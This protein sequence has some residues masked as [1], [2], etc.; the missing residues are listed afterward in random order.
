M[1]KFRL[2][3]EQAFSTFLE[4]LYWEMDGNKSMCVDSYILEHYERKTSSVLAAWLELRSINAKIPIENKTN[5][6]RMWSRLFFDFQIFDDLKDIKQD[7]NKQP[8]LL[9]LTANSYPTEAEWLKN[10]IGDLSID[11]DLHGTLKINLNMPLSVT[12]LKLVSSVNANYYLSPFLKAV[13]N[14][15]WKKSW[16]SPFLSFQSKKKPIYVDEICNLNLKFNNA[17]KPLTKVTLSAIMSTI[18][19]Y[20]ETSSIE[21]MFAHCLDI[22]ALDKRGFIYRYGSLRGVWNYTLYAPTMSLRNKQSLFIEVLNNG[23]VI[24]DI[25]YWLNYLS[26]HNNS[27][28]EIIKYLK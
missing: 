14:Y 10:N 7:F 1:E 5:E 23:K 4:E 26:I 22:M 12:H 11:G 28:Y 19:L 6:I 16:L 20:E 2:S 3:V 27:F 8:N 13:Q 24:N 17:T 15:R 9:E 21:L 18:I 25:K